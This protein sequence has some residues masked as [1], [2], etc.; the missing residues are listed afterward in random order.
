MIEVSA[1]LEGSANMEPLAFTTDKMSWAFLMSALRHMQ[2]DEG[3]DSSVDLN[4]EAP[5]CVV[6]SCIAVEAF[7][8]E[9]SSLTNTF[10][11][12]RSGT[13][14]AGRLNP[15]Q[16]LHA[17]TLKEVAR[18][19]CD[20]D[21]SFYVRYKRL[22]CVFGIDKPRLLADLSV[23]G[24]AR[25][26]LV[27]FRKCDVP[28]IQDQNGVIRVGQDLPAE[29]AALQSKYYKGRCVLAPGEGQEWTLR[30]ETDAMAAWSVNLALDAILF[31]LD[32]LPAGEY[33]D[34]VWK[35]YANRDLTFSTLF[36]RGKKELEAWWRTVVRAES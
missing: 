13:D 27:H 22:L 5:P 21:G 19:R 8:N 33:R 6:L 15:K 2:A 30:M 32:H 31:V 35:S 28:I 12:E 7:V 18:I 9:L 3:M 10:L 20:G 16:A 23:L 29:I 34:F 24:K 36:A 11:F 25:D 26:A 17:G 1:Q 4:L 14:Y